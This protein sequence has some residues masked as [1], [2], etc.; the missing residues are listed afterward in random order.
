[1][2]TIKTVAYLLIENKNLLLVRARN[3]IAF[4]MPGGKQDPGENSV[5]ALIREIKEEIGIV[6]NL[7]NKGYID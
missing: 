4:Y 1:M 6:K 7:K 2:H 5:T 3:K